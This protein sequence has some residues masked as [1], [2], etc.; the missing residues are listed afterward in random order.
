MKCFVCNQAEAIPG[1]TSMLLE[2]AALSL[3]IRNVPARLCPICGEA[4]V[5]EAVAA[6]LL[7]QAEKAIKAGTKV[8]VCEYA[9][10][11]D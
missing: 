8:D 7:Y 10:I 11:E 2:R 9:V 4:Y 3:T 6:N 5:E 1:R